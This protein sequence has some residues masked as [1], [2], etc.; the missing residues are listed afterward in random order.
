MAEIIARFADGRLL[1]QEDKAVEQGY[2]MSGYS[3]YGVPIRIGHV[4]SVEKVLS[5]DAYMS[6]YPGMAG[7]IHAPLR[8]ILT[9]GDT[10]LVVLRRMD[11]GQLTLTGIISGIVAS[12][13]WLSGVANSISGGITVT[14]T[15]ISGAASYGVL[16]GV[17]SGLGYLGELTSGLVAI[18]GLLKVV[19]NVIAR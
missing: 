2:K 17:T 3:T 19:A 13:I 16:S 7:E 14:G 1:V 15:T 11:I 12:G 18:S 4:N 10:I 6:G 5:I 8:E 9:S